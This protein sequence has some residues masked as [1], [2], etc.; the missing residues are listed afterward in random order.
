MD[1]FQIPFY[2]EKIFDFKIDFHSSIFY[3]PYAVIWAV[4]LL[5]VKYGKGLINS[6][7]KLKFLRFIGSI[8]FSMYLFHLL[9][10]D[11][12]EYVDM[13]EYLRIYVFFFLTIMFSSLSYLFIELPLSKI[14]I[15]SDDRSTNALK[16]KITVNTD[17]HCVKLTKNPFLI[18][19]ENT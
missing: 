9:F 5:S 10:L 3:L 6:L 14:K 15:S 4:I 17:K 7:L 16:K 13:P 2:F 1:L 18:E 12:V 8:S 19:N 11:I